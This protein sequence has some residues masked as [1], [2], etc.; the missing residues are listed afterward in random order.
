MNARKEPH[1]RARNPGRECDSGVAQSSQHA[2][3]S[4]RHDGVEHV[5]RDAEEQE[6]RG[7]GTDQRVLQHVGGDQSTL[8]EPTDRRA[9]GDQEYSERRH[10]E[11]QMPTRL[12]R[13][14]RDA[15]EVD[16]REPR[17][18][19]DFDRGNRPAREPRRERRRRPLVVVRRAEAR[20][21]GEC[22]EHENERRD[23][24]GDQQ[25][26][27]SRHTYRRTRKRYMPATM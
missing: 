8:S 19:R 13:R 5:G 7:H 4:G 3:P 12:A 20:P 25:S 26:N 14:V 24:R 18:Q 16:K 6:E 15:S 2:T 1:E 22:C 27:R 11:R 21:T 9:N 10:A 23:A 17:D